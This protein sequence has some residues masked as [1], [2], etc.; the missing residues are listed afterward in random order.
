MLCGA[1]V[2]PLFAAFLNNVTVLQSSTYYE[3]THTRS[4]LPSMYFYESG[5]GK[6]NIT[7]P[8][9]LKQE[10]VEWTEVVGGENVTYNTSLQDIA[11][12]FVTNLYTSIYQIANIR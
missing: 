1:A 2:L 4:G 5:N 6:I 7:L 12:R 10:I 9:V 8:S 11:F 3:G